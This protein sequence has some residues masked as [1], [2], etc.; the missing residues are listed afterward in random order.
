MNP[1]SL[2]MK[3][4]AAALLLVGGVAALP[5]AH[6]LG[7]A[8][9]TSIQN[10]ATIS[11]SVGGNAQTPIESSPTGNST[12]GTNAGT[13][14]TFVVDNKVDLTVTESGGAATVVN[15]GQANAVAT[16][17]VTNTGNSPQAYQLSV[18]NVAAGANLFGNADNSDVSNLRVFVD[19][20]GNNVY[21][22]ATDTATAINSRSAP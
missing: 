5:Q 2:P 14:T 13:S 22:P 18:A 12:P 8:A 10:R 20:N 7:T 21:D 3:R 11:Y 6:A 17:I 19:A 15:P 1:L 4:A 16:Y 9:N